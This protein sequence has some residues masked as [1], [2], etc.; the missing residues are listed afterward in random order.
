MTN[1]DELNEL[2]NRL[3]TLEKENKILKKTVS[4]PEQMFMI[5]QAF[6]ESWKENYEKLESKLST[7]LKASEGMEKA[8]EM[9]YS[10]LVESNSPRCDEWS[11]PAKIIKQAL[12]DFRALKEMK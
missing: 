9:L 1:H 2:Q 7:L 10:E 5:R 6:E 12:A 11:T 3:S 4:T 8:L